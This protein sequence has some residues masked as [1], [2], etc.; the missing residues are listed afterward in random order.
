MSTRVQSAAEPPACPI[1]STLYK[2]QRPAAQLVPGVGLSP[3]ILSCNLPQDAKAML[4]ENWTARPSEDTDNPDAPAAPSFNPAAPEFNELASRI[5]KSLQLHTWNSLTIKVKQLEN[6]SASL[7]GDA[8]EAKLAEQEE[9][10][11]QLADAEAQL[12][13]LKGSF[14]PDPLALVNWMQALFGLADAGCTTFDVHG[15][16]WPY[17]S[18][19]DMFGRNACSTAFQG[20]EQILGIFKR[21]YESERGPDKIQVLAK[22]GPNCFADGFGADAM[23]ESAVERIRVNVLGQEG[24]QGALDLLQLHWFEFQDHDVLPVL[25]TLGRLVEDKTEWNAETNEMMIIEPKKIKTIGLID[26]PCEVI[27]QVLRAGVPVTSVQVQYSILDTSAQAT[28]ECC[29]SAGIKVL[30]RGALAG[31]LIS[32]RYL[33][34]SCPSTTSGAE[35]G[36]F[37]ETGVDCLPAALDCV[38]RYGGWERFQVLLRCLKQIGDKHKV[39]VEAVA[40]RWVMDQGLFPITPIKWWPTAWTTFGYCHGNA[41]GGLCVDAALFQK[42]SFLDHDDV[43]KLSQLCGA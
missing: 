36:S 30:A 1:L 32:D 29:K 18:L 17:G 22:L 26:F 3:V 25:R 15:R 33:G 2:S 20:A 19:S 16:F 43:T 4:S 8:K 10:K 24:L 13:E 5:S 28:M 14:D 11:N 42:E 38:R 37:E 31:G 39:K 35:G 34:V 27:V 9:A 6:E 23:V 40:L 7:T 21:R 41:T 12:N